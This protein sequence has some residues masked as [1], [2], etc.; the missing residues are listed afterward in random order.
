MANPLAVLYFALEPNSSQAAKKMRLNVSRVVGFI[1]LGAG[2]LG[3]FTYA[4][5]LRHQGELAVVAGLLISGFL[6]LA[7]LLHLR[8]RCI[9]SLPVATVCILIGLVVGAIYD[10]SML[11][12]LLGTCLGSAA[13]WWHCSKKGRV[14]A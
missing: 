11:G 2:L 9:S 12:V 10:S 6:L 1:L 4:D 3:P 7:P 14:A 13:V 5:D 8:W